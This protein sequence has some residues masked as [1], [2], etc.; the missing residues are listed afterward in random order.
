LPWQRSGSMVSTGVAEATA[1]GMIHPV[2]RE[3][4]NPGFARIV[5][6]GVIVN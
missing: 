6:Q 4:G 5:A 3:S 2:V 1:S